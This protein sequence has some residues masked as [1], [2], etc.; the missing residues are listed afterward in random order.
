M[1]RDVVK[2]HLDGLLRFIDDDASAFGEIDLRAVATAVVRHE[3][4]FPS[5]GRWNVTDIKDDVREPIEEHPRLDLAFGLRGNDVERDFAG[6]LVSG[7]DG[8]HQHIGCGG[9]AD[10]GN[11]PNRTEQPPHADATCLERHELAI[12]GK[13]AERHEQ[14]HQQ[15]HRNRQA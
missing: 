9:A 14:R 6:A 3:H 11:Q 5:A 4:A 7:R 1:P 10:Y 12:G 2:H 13:A 8:D 15:R